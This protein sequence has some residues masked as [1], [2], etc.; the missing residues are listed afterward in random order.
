MALLS[1]TTPK[2]THQSQDSNRRSLSPSS[3]SPT[4]K[5][6]NE[7][8]ALHRSHK[9]TPEK[10][11][12]WYKRKIL[13]SD[14]DEADDTEYTEIA[15]DNDD[16]DVDDSDSTEK[17]PSPRKTMQLQHRDFFDF[18]STPINANSTVSFSSPMRMLNDLHLKSQIDYDDDDDAEEEKPGHIFI[19][20]TNDIAETVHE[21]V[22]IDDYVHD[23]NSIGNKTIFNNSDESDDDFPISP[24]KFI[25]KKKRMHSDAIGS[26]MVTPIM[27]QDSHMSICNTAN[28]SNSSTF[29]LSFSTNDSTPCPPQPKRKKLKF[30][31]AS[32][33]TILD[34]HYA[35]KTS[36]Q[37]LP[38]RSELPLQSFADD[39]DD[40]DDV[41]NDEKNEPHSFGK[42]N[43]LEST[44][45]SQSTPT[46][47][48]ASTPP[49]LQPQPQPQPQPSNTECTQEYGPN[50]NGYKFVY[51]K[52][53]S[54][55]FR[56]ET[57]VNQNRYT[58][59]RD[60]YNRQNYSVVG[61]LP[62]TSAGMMDEEGVHVGDKRINDPYLTPQIEHSGLESWND[63]LRVE[64]HNK[65]KLPLLPPHFDQDDLSTD[66]ILH[67]ITQ[68]SLKQFYNM[69][70]EGPMLDLLRQERIKWHPDKW[71]GRLKQYPDTNITISVID[72]LSQTIN[73]L[74]DNYE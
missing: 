28:T 68:D 32:T 15:E 17:T 19:E 9:V 2:L 58:Q 67:L 21:D 74:I 1:H 54:A 50:I 3:S 41:D 6:H 36:L 33:A 59:M 27:Q 65:L 29:K 71:V 44:P 39:D 45:I 34:L 49:L 40:D 31:H 16:V 22:D 5:R 8:V 72:R 10:R 4:H 70:I 47:S 66:Q 38:Q 7:S 14:I 25:N 23:G 62:V 37:E 20:A 48:R 12:V 73:A 63:R 61:E 30:K 46:S 24:P 64:Y 56:Y 55:Q 69:I 53:K 57:P 35:R 60:S 18:V 51:P 43:D 11:R 52:S 26:R 42:N 13:T